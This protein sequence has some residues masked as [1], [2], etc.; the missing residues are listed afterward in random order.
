[1]SSL[2]PHCART[3]GALALALSAACAATEPRAV[4]FAT[5][6][7]FALPRAPAPLAASP[8]IGFFGGLGL[9]QSTF[10]DYELDGLPGA[11]VDDTDTAF[12]LFTGYR[13]TPNYGVLMGYIDHGSV[14]ASGPVGEGGSPFDD[15]VGYKSTLLCAMAA[16]P[17]A[18]STAILGFTGAA[19]WQQDVD[20]E[21][22]YTPPGLGG[23]GVSSN[24]GADE[25]GVSAVIGGGVN[26]FFDP[27]Q[28]F[29]LSLMWF[30]IIDAGDQGATGHDSDIDFVSLGITASQ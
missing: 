10:H 29:G 8:G 12:S 7:G 18:P 3:V 28:H 4:S 26:Y 27:T 25:S 20:Y 23:E 15:E 16:W 30:R 21:E 11:E 24:Y 5:E 9:G 17:I 13:W 22:G 14:R 19:Y 2:T 1:M 6:P